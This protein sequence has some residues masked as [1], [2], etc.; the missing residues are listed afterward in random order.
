MFKFTT[1]LTTSGS[2][3]LC[4]YFTTQSTSA[5]E[6]LVLLEKHLVD[7]KYNGVSIL[8][9]NKPT[10]LNALTFTMGEEF[11]KLVAQ[12]ENE[13]DLKCVVLT[14]AGKAFSS[15]GDLNFLR[16]RAADTPE[17]N[18]KIMEKFYKTFLCIRN[19]PVPVIAAVNGHAIGAGLC[20]ALATDIRIASTKAS[21]GLTFVGVNLHPGMAAT[22]FL[23]RMVGHQVASRLILTGDVLSA[24]ES[25]RL[26]IVVD[27]AEPDQ[28]M[29]NA[30]EMAS[31]IAKR[32]PFAVR[33]STKT[34]RTLSGLGLDSSLQREADAQSQCYAQETFLSNPI[35][36]E[37]K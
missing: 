29:N 5:N 27:V 15:G 37:K 6:P 12:L 13:S 9:L 30:L 25:K 34:L 33:S 2:R 26:G 36:L 19:I 7:G 4:R 14:G 3:Y 11:K 1:Q 21:L 17:N 28:L 35:F 22:H 23:P 18:A 31:T 8:K 20:L 10:T 16:E 32:S 24:E